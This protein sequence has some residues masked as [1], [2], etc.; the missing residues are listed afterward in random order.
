MAEEGK[1]SGGPKKVEEMRHCLIFDDERCASTAM[2][3][4]TRMG[5]QAGKTDLGESC[6]VNVLQPDLS[7]EEIERVRN[8]LEKV[9]ARLGGIYDGTQFKLGHAD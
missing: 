4:V 6:G 3:E 1:R 7:E 5:L 8:C 9:A 2:A